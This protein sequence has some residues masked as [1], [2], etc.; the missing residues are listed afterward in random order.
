MVLSNAV[1]YCN[2]IA[3]LIQINEHL[4]INLKLCRYL[5]FHYFQ[6]TRASHFIKANQI[7]FIHVNG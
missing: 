1:E 7:M 3:Y 2:I 5:V 4:N 6:F